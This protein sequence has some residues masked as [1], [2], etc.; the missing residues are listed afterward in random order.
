MRQTGTVILI[1]ALLPLFGVA[2]EYKSYSVRKDRLVI[3]LSGGELD[4]VP[5]TAKAV[6]VIWSREKAKPDSELILINKPPAPAFHCSE[7]ASALLLSTGAVTVSFDKATGAIDYQDVSGRVFLR[8][9][10]GS[11]KLRPDSVMGEPCFVAEQSFESP[12][13]EYLFGLGQFQDGNFN[14]RTEYRRF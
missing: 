5:L 3:L 13:D 8:E 1:L 12:G 9:K 7:R 6:R 14:L 10:A 2:Q 11:R 4:I